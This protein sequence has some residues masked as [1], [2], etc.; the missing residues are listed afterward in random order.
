MEQGE[1]DAGRS[2]MAGLVLGDQ[3][4]ATTVARVAEL[5][6]E[7][8]GADFASV[9]V[10]SPR[11]PTTWAST[12]PTAERLDESQYASERSPCVAA[13]MTQVVVRIDDTGNDRRWPAFR[14]AAKAIGV[15]ST[16]SLPITAGDNAVGTFNLYSGRA[17]AFDDQP[18]YELNLFVDQAAVLLLNAR[19]LW[20]ARDIAEGLRT[21]MQSRA[22][23]EQ[24]VG[25]LMAGG[26]RT[27]EEAFAVLVRASQRENRKVR[28][29]AEEIVERAIG[30]KQ[31]PGAP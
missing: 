3:T 19:D 25:I 15:R 26:G 21:A 28:V 17:G 12:G 10:L 27:P 11:G 31:P 5:A 13:L 8:S 4:L 1:T 18:S 23:I 2:E 29:I 9:T 16:L 24:A 20:E 30:R 22:T 6:R 14:A 7:R